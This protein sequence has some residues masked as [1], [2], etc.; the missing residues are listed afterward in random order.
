MSSDQRIAAKSRM[1]PEQ[2]AYFEKEWQA[3]FKRKQKTLLMW[4]AGVSILVCFLVVVAL[5]EQGQGEGQDLL[6]FRVFHEYAKTVYNPP[7][8]HWGPENTNRFDVGGYVTEGDE[9]YRGI[10]AVASWFKWDGGL[11]VTCWIMF[12]GYVS[13]TDNDAEITIRDYEVI[14]GHDHPSN[15]RSLPIVKGSYLREKIKVKLR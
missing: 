15:Y 7:E 8:G 6:A 13:L 11:D 3:H 12:D 5:S 10:F 14:C 4:L 2:A 9:E 1:T